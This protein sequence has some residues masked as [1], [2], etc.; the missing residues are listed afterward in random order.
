MAQKHAT[1]AT[2]VLGTSWVDENGDKDDTLSTTRELLNFIHSLDLEYGAR[3]PKKT[4]SSHL[5]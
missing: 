4:D 3:S 2:V 1:S 5:N